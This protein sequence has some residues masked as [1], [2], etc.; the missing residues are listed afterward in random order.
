MTTPSCVRGLIEGEAGD[1]T[2]ADHLLAIFTP[3]DDEG[4]DGRVHLEGEA[5]LFCVCGA[6]GSASELDAHFLAVSTPAMSPK[7]RARRRRSAR[8]G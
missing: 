7:A 4:T 1:E 6:G 3:D 5:S 2:I 8:S